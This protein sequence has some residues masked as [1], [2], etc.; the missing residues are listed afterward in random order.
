M[1]GNIENSININGNLQ[2]SLN[3]DG[4]INNNNIL[5]GTINTNTQDENIINGKMEEQIKI[6]GTL[7]NNIELNG[8][9]GASVGIKE[10]IDPIF[11]SSPAYNITN[12][13]INNWNNK[14]DGNYNE[15]I[16]QPSINSITLTGNKTLEDLGIP[17]NGI[18]YIIG[19]QN[20][21]TNLWTGVSTDTNCSNGNVY[22][23]KVIIYHLPQAGNSSSAT[24]N[25][26][27]PDNSTTGAINIYR[28][29]TTTVTTN[30]ASGCDILMVYDGTQW[31][32]NAYVDTNTNTIGY[33]LRT[34]SSV[35]KN[36]ANTSIYRYQLLVETENGLEPFT[37][38]SNSTKATKTQLSPKY[39]PGGNIRYYGSTTA[40]ESGNDLATG[41]LWQQYNV[42]LRYSFNI[43]ASTFIAKKPVYMKMFKNNDGTLSP[44]YPLLGTGHPLTQ[45]LP[46]EE[47]DIVYVLL[48]QA[49]SGY[50]IELTPLHTIYEYKN[51]KIREYIEES[52]SGGSGMQF[53]DIPIYWDEEEEIYKTDVTAEEIYSALEENKL[54]RIEDSG[55]YYICTTINTDE[56]FCF[57]SSNF[58]EVESVTMFNYSLIVEGDEVTVE[59]RQLVLQ[60]V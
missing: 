13:D 44:V 15:L 59:V 38:T 18:E 12:N 53:F 2:T 8:E 16:N 55:I 57:I 52:S 36:G 48:G 24:L 21:A 29:A 20:E 42:D 39:I 43:T 58:F 19:T 50:Q 5:N 22:T 46:T 41:V 14:S 10:E 37:S 9:L 49:Y 11:I 45:E 27:L 25:L 51:G 60:V 31:K 26:T 1:N 4:T 54:I 6:N 30:F 23:G 35:Y 7:S 28:L 40:V 3:L 34:N 47:D 33:Q 32:I 56:D 17:A